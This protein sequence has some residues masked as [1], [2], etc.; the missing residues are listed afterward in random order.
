LFVELA[1]A[2]STLQSRTCYLTDNADKDDDG[3]GNGDQD[4]NDED[5]GVVVNQ[6][7]DKDSAPSDVREAELNSNED[8]YTRKNGKGD[9]HYEYKYKHKCKHKYKEQHCTE[10]F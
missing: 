9:S 10:D 4:N 6:V 3:G 5:R 2:I 8:F 7:V 1:N